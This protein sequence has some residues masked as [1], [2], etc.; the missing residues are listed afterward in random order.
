MLVVWR[1]T[2]QYV[3]ERLAQYTFVGVFKSTA[4]DCLQV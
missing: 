3:G 2:E 1:C 4:V